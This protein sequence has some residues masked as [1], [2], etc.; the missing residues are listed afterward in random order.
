MKTLLILPVALLLT[1]CV[2]ALTPEPDAGAAVDEEKIG[3]EPIADSLLSETGLESI[4]GP[5]GVS[6]PADLAAARESTIFADIPQTVN[7]VPANTPPP[8]AAAPLDI[9]PAPRTVGPGIVVPQAPTFQF[10]PSLGIF[11]GPAGNAGSSAGGS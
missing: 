5:P 10:S 9:G 3:D 2:Y 1:G 4:V 11:G 8:A 7:P 6:S